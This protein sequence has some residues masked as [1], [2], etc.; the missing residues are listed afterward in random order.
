VI[1]PVFDNDASKAF[2]NGLILGMAARSFIAVCLLYLSEIVVVPILFTHVMTAET[3]ASVKVSV[4]RAEWAKCGKNLGIK[5]LLQVQMQN[6][7]PKPLVLGRVNVVQERL[8]RESK[9]GKLQLVAT[10]ATPDEFASDPATPLAAPQATNICGR[11]A[12]ME[13]FKT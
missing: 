4:N 6:T 13:M 9:K 2:I 3:P 1:T 11:K 7:S 8:Y 5:L 12:T 10:T